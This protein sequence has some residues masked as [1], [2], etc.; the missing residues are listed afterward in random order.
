MNNYWSNTYI[1]FLQLYKFFHISLIHSQLN[2]HLAINFATMRN[3]NLYKW[4][5]FT[6]NS[7]PSS[8][9]FHCIYIIF[10]SEQA[11][12]IFKWKCQRMNRCHT[13]DKQKEVE[14]MK[15]CICMCIWQMLSQSS[16]VS[17]GISQLSCSVPMSCFMLCQ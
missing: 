13:N 1:T 11:F 16:M 12:I 10:N 4:W 5:F 6:W 15:V 2:F 8:V 3:K 14:I 9:N 17:L 7:V